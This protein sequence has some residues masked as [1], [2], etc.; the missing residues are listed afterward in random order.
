M[1]HYY[2]Y[3]LSNK[4]ASQKREGCYTEYHHGCDDI[5]IFICDNIQVSEQCQWDMV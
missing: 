3:M 5:M 4:A 1:T 2:H